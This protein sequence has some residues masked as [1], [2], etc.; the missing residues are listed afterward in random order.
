V[1]AAFQVFVGKSYDDTDATHVLYATEGVLIR[2]MYI[3][4]QTTLEAWKE[5]KKSLKE[6]LALV[7]GRDRIVPSTE[8]LLNPTKEQA[9]SRPFADRSVFDRHYRPHSPGGSSNSGRE[10]GN[11]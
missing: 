8:S 10:L 5:W 11:E 3:T 4:G 6:E 1:Q 7:Q 2:L 9:N